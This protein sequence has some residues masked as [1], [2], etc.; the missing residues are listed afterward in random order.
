MR[1]G[2]GMFAVL[3]SLTIAAIAQ[4]APPEVAAKAVDAGEHA[5]LQAALDAL[6]ATGGI[7]RIPPG[8]YEIT[9]PLVL[10][11]GDVKIEGSGTATHIHNANQEG[12]AALIIHGDGAAGKAATRPKLWR[13]M[14]SDLRITGTEKS[15]DG[16]VANVNEIFIQGVT[17][18]NHGGHG[19]VLDHCY[20]D[21]R[22]NDCLITYNKKSGVQL[23]GCHDIVVSGNQFEE[24]ND[25]LRCH[26]G[27]NL[28]MT[29]NNVDDHLRHG[30]VIENT[31][32]SVVSGNMIEECQGRG[33]ILDRDCYGITVSSN[34]IAHEF[35]G[36]V[37]LV[38]A[39]GITISANTFPIVKQFGVM[40]R[41]GSGRVTVT[42]N[43]FADTYIGEGKTKRDPKPTKSEKSPNAAG[44]VVLEGTSDVTITGNTFS[45]LKDAGAVRVTKAS[46]RVVI[47]G[48]VVTDSAWDVEKLSDS[49]V[50]DNI[51]VK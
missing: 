36:G 13:V 10:K 6:P 50:K 22:I 27:F 33:V 34:V 39:H 24:N 17:V 44:G 35:D 1:F 42:G 8:N 30:V 32:A 45:G 7:V 2:M 19:I 37:E 11:V 47:T 46:K 3:L 21:P 51:G 43:S 5:S 12:K 31:Y 20:E 15:G 29:G 49:V 25:A 14:I 9:E 4:D 16:I 40:I 23:I 18:S 48:N 41:E 28:C 26:D 38:D